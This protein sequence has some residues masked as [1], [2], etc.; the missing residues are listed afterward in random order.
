ME[1]GDIEYVI[2]EEGDRFLQAAGDAAGPYSVQ[3]S[4]GTI[5]AM[6]EV[7]GGADVKTMRDVLLAYRRGDDRWRTACA[8]SSM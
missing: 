1:R 2:L 3:F 8:W 4:P 7:P 6:I 5:D